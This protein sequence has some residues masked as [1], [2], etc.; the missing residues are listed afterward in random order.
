MA[1]YIN[2]VWQTRTLYGLLVFLPNSDLILTGVKCFQNFLN[3]KTP[4]TK[5]SR[6]FLIFTLCKYLTRSLIR[7]TN[8]N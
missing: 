4:E 6:F 3:K 5:F 1:N 2:E 8:K 7:S